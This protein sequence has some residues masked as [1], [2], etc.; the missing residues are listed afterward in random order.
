MGGGVSLF[1]LRYQ[2]SLMNV[3]WYLFIH[4]PAHLRPTSLQRTRLPPYLVRVM[5]TRKGAEPG[6]SQRGRVLLVGLDPNTA[7]L[8]DE[9]MEGG[10]ACT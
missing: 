4:C 2:G 3:P 9:E 8:E 7:G 6:S 10:G 1:I 5:P